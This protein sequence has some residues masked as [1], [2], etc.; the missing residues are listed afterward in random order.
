MVSCKLHG[1]GIPCRMCVKA[2]YLYCLVDNNKRIKENKPLDE[3]GKVMLHDIEHLKQLLIS[4]GE[5]I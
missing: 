4:L 1:F 3:A 2:D 5:N